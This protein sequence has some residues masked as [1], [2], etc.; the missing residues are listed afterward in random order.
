MARD[1]DLPRF[2]ATIPS[3]TPVDGDTRPSRGGIV[4]GER[5]EL[6]I[7]AVDTARRRSPRTGKAGTYRILRTADWVNVVAL[8]PERQVILIEQYRHGIDAATL[9][10]PG[11][12]VDPGEDPADAASRELREETGYTGGPPELLGRVHPNPAIQDNLCSAYLIRDCR[13]THDTEWDS[14]EHILIH[15]EEA[16]RIPELLHL[17][18]ITHSLVIAAFHWWHLRESQLR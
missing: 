5:L 11:G 14:G 6:G 13:L 2:A 3:F 15:L 18:H 4:D 17:G 8:T 10:I 9:E 7:F 1:R 12:M 16:A